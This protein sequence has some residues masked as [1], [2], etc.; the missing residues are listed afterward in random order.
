MCN[1]EYVI[2]LSFGIHFEKKNVKKKHFH[3]SYF[4][5]DLMQKPIVIPFDACFKC[6]IYVS[7]I[8]GI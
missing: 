5:A 7:N 8:M 6:N 1:A 3:Q 2:L 4:E